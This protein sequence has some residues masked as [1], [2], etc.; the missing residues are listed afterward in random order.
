MFKSVMFYT[1]RLAAMR[2]FY[3]NILELEITERLEDRF[4]VRIGETEVTFVAT[5]RPAFYH[6]AINIPGNQFTMLKYWVKDRVPLN[7]DGGVDEV[8][9][10]NFDADSMYFE[11]PAGNIVEL[12]GRRKKDLFGD[13]SQASFLNVSEVGIVPRDVAKAGGD[14]MKAGIPLRGGTEVDPHNLNFLGRGETFFVVVPEG[15][16]W[17]FSKKD[18]ESHPLKAALDDGLAVQLDDDGTLTVSEQED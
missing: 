1:D 5:D 4:T 8:Y 6:F 11:D 2:R 9:F 18:A 13:V 7:W 17:Y 10:R 14:L 15:R 3:G 12:I 16:R